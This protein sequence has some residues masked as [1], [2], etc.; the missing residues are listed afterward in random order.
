MRPPPTYAIA[1]PTRGLLHSRTLEALVVA[2]QRAAELDVAWLVGWA[3]T[4]DL[5][6]PEAHETAAARAIATGAD[7]VWFVEED[8]VPPAD[9]LVELFRLMAGPS[10]A[11]AALDY[12][13]A[14]NPVTGCFHHADDG[15]L[16]WCGLGCT[17]VSARVL[18][19][20]PRP[21]VTEGKAVEM[22]GSR[23]R[24][25]DVE[26]DYGGQDVWL[27]HR[28]RAAGLRLAGSDLLCGHLRVREAGAAAT[29]HGAH[30]VAELGPIE[31]F[32]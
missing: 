17:L 3:I 20:L 2:A 28:L 1:L 26:P 4:H 29:N 9:A 10:V 18:A 22:I 25:V 6:I 8:N 30:R 14:T 32:H 24:V 21:W 16:L 12:P 13:L 27:C 15:E 11:L 23:T 5:P 19:S 7:Y 31:R